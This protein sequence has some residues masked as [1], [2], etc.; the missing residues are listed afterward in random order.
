MTSLIR[1][2]RVFERKREVSRKPILNICHEVHRGCTYYSFVAYALRCRR[3]GVA[4][5]F[6]GFRGFIVVRSLFYRVYATEI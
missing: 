6:M 2:E 1:L 5:D 4:A 3:Y